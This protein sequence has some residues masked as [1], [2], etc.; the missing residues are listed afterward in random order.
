MA[1]MEYAP[2][3]SLEFATTPGDMSKQMASSSSRA[4][5]PWGPTSARLWIH[6]LVI[7][8][9][10]ACIVLSLIPVT[11][12]QDDR[13][14]ETYA[15]NIYW[16]ACLAIAPFLCLIPSAAEIATYVV[17]AQNRGIH[18]FWFLGASI[19]SM[20]S[21]WT[22]AIMNSV[23]VGLKLSDKN[24]IF[25]NYRGDSCEDRANFL[26]GNV[27]CYNGWYDREGLFVALTVLGFVLAAAE[28]VLCCFLSCRDVRIRKKERRALRA[29]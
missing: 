22:A 5:R 27:V 12:L 29:A 25:L 1:S 18:P 4:P 21:A 3:S 28:S 26:D 23:L 19:F 14:G 6:I 2:Q 10:I 8:L 9:A 20:L 11:D 17:R 24:S 13:L 7:I 16:T 15:M